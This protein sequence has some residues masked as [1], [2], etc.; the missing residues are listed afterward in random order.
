MLCQTLKTAPGRAASGSKCA[1]ASPTARP[2]ITGTST[3]IC[4]DPLE[5]G[6]GQG[7][8]HPQH[9]DAQQHLDR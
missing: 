9:N 5:I 3:R 6:Q 1:L 4:Q 2:A 8:P 7:Y